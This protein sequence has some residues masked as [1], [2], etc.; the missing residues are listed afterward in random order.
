MK[1]TPV[2][3]MNLDNSDISDPNKSNNSINQ[4]PALPQ[5]CRG[6]ANLY[7]LESMVK[8]NDTPCDPSDVKPTA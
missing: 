6:K 7:K 4:R 8:V 1:H 5:T 2:L 3:T